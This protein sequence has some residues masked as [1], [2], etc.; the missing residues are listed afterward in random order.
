[1]DLRG[2]KWLGAGEDY[3]VRNF[4]TCTLHHTFYGDLIKED[5]MGGACS[6]QVRDE[7]F[8]QH[9]FGKLEGRRPTARLGLK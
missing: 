5:E 9:F 3:T 6:T 7:Q 4:I 8:I 1:L 2:R